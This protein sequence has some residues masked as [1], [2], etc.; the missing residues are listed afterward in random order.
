MK[1]QGYSVGLRGGFRTYTVLFSSFLSIHAFGTSPTYIAFEQR[2]LRCH[3]SEIHSARFDLC[4]DPNKKSPV[5][6]Q[7]HRRFHS[8][9]CQ[10][11]EYVIESKVSRN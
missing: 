3:R 6:L 7:D 8:Q 4:M 5:N 1:D 11:N 10:N 9:G 2:K